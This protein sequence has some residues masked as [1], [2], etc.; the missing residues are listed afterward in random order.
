MAIFDEYEPKREAGNDVKVAFDFPFKIFNE[1]DLEVFKI[2]T[3]VTPNVETSQVLNTDYTVSINT[4]TNGGTVTYAVAP[5]SDDD[6]FISRVTTETQ[7]SRLPAVGK[8]P[9]VTV[10][11]MADRNCILIQNLSEV[12]S[13]SIVGSQFATG[14]DYELPVPSAGEVIGWNGT[15]TGFANYVLMA[16]LPAGALDKMMYHNGIAWTTIDIDDVTLESSGSNLQIK[17]LGVTTAKLITTILNGFTAK[18][19]PVLADSIALIDSEA[20]NINKKATLTSIKTALQ[21][22]LLKVQAK[23]WVKYSGTTLV[24]SDSFNVDNITDNGTGDQSVNWTTDFANANYCVVSSGSTGTT[25]RVTAPDNYAVGSVD[26]D[27]RINGGTAV[28]TEV[29]T[30]V[31]FGDQ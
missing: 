4:V 31:A 1:V 15:A 12:V 2:D 25:P 5:T 23:G 30:V 22:P 3:S 19:T 10:E 21:V 16:G 28:D 29:V 27:C 11:N 7:P 24:V 26:I 9:Q 18:V 14:I 8:M 17:D 20:A 6:S 13:R